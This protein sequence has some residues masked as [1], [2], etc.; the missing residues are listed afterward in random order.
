MA[1]ESKPGIISWCKRDVRYKTNP[2][3]RSHPSIVMQTGLGSLMPWGEYCKPLRRTHRHTD[4][5]WKPKG[6][7]RRRHLPSPHCETGLITALHTWRCCLVLCRPLDETMRARF[8]LPFA[9]DK[10][11]RPKWPLPCLAWL[12]AETEKTGH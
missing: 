7:Q 2:V 1:P 11:S 5:K 9:T 8:S 10:L 6:S 3:S 12:A 4:R